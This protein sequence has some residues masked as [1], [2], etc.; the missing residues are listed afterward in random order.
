VQ[1]EFDLFATVN[2]GSLVASYSL[3]L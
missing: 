3:E 2:I 1:R